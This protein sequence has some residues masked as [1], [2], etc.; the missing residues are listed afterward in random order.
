MIHL[1]HREK[2]M[3]ITEKTFGGQKKYNISN[4]ELLSYTVI[5]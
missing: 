1:E 3:S 2:I 4:P 5:V